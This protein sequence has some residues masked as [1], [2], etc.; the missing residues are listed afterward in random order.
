MSAITFADKETLKNRASIPEVNKITSGNINEI[1]ASVNALYS[2]GV[3]GGFLKQRITLTEAEID[4]LNSSPY[5][6]IPAPGAGKKIV[7]HRV[8]TDYQYGTT[9]YDNGLAESLYFRANSTNAT[10]PSI[11]INFS[12]SVE[13]NSA[14]TIRFDNTSLNNQALYLTSDADFT[15]GDG[16]V[17]LIIYYTIED[18]F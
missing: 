17:N 3:E 14:P 4:V 2:G 18:V 12:T 7:I 13:F 11:A 9:I 1:K 5:L 10:S 15:Q 8:S 6:A 16:V